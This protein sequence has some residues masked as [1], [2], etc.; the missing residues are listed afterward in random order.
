MWSVGVIQYVLLSGVPPFWG[1][2]EQQIFDA[3][4]EAKID[5]LSDPWSQIS[6]AAKDLIQ[7]LLCVNATTRLTPDQVLMHPWILRHTSQ[8]AQSQEKREMRP[9]SLEIR[10]EGSKTEEPI[11][12]V[13]L[14][15]YTSQPPQIQENREMKPHNLESSPKGSKT[16]ETVRE[17]ALHDWSTGGHCDIE[18]PEE[19]VPAH[20][21]IW[22]LKSMPPAH[23]LATTASGY[24]VSNSPGQLPTVPC[25]IFHQGL[26][27]TSEDSS[28]NFEVAVDTLLS[29]VPT[30]QGFGIHPVSPPTVHSASV[31]SSRVSLS[32]LSGRAPP[33]LFENDQ[34]RDI[35]PVFVSKE[36]LD[37]SS[38]TTSSF[39]SQS[40]FLD[41]FDRCT[42]FSQFAELTFADFLGTV[43]EDGYTCTILKASEKG[44]TVLIDSKKGQFLVVYDRERRRI[45]WKT[46][47]PQLSLMF[48]IQACCASPGL[49]APTHPF[50]AEVS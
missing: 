30:H 33:A 43:M 25:S 36:H 10:P 47:K 48:Q 44:Y 49:H 29:P 23:S 11:R 4:N 15:D 9:E 27:E 19:A 28:D 2:T 16:E 40:P 20:K 21:N 17:V 50:S 46:L 32:L 37:A 26:G 12:E 39:P 1:E 7:G 34:E 8:P 6:D 13:A 35:S 3:I 41:D 42:S 24:P 5:F 14:Q 31:P 38:P 22:R 45:G 18:P